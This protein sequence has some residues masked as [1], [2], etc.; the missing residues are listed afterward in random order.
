[1]PSDQHAINASARELAL[2]AASAARALGAEV[3]AGAT[4]E[5]AMRAWAD[6]R[7][8]EAMRVA[9]R[10]TLDQARA[11]ADAHSN[12]E[13]LPQR[14]VRAQTLLLEVDAAIAAA[15]SPRQRTEIAAVV[16][17]AR[18]A[19]SAAVD[20]VDQMDINARALAELAARSLGV[21]G[22]NK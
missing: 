19:R 17:G 20:V 10:D 5:S 22:A 16:E 6:A 12:R 15:H 1:V 4:P 18:G 9:P 11:R 3:P 8:A 21:E 7:I 14:F 13:G 2:A